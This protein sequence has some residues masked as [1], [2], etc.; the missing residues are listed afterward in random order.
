[1]GKTWENLGINGRTPW[2]NYVKNFRI[3]SANLSIL[4]KITSQKLHCFK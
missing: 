4:V 1:M 3:S 2:G